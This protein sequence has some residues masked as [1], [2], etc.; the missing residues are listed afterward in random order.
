MNSPAPRHVIPLAPHEDLREAR[1]IIDQE[2][3]ALLDLSRRIDESFI[4]A[5]DRIVR[6][7][8]QIVVTGMGK[9][10]LIGQ[11]IA[12]TMSSTGTRA[13]FLHPS[14]ALHGDLG[15]LHCDDL[16]LALSNS[17]ETEEV[18]RLLPLVQRTG[19]PIIAITA[20]KTSTLGRNA[21][22]VI[23]LG[24]LR[25]AGPHGLAPTTSTTAMLALGDALALV[26]G[27]RRGL[28]PEKFALFHPGGRLGDQLRTVREVM[29]QGS[30][31]R[32]APSSATI[33]E[34]FVGLGKPGRRTGA[35][36]L[37]DSDQ[38]LVGLFTDSD[39][40]RLLEQ[41]RESQL[42]RPIS[43]VMTCNPL[44]IGPER[45]LRDA[46]ELLSQN[47]V[48]EL[49]VVDVFEQPI[50]LIDITDVLALVPSEAAA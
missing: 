4:A 35:V 50:G 11:K 15:K 48:S 34:A 6:T 7:N 45:M 19:A 9:A 24:R 17:G 2:A 21:E 38:R 3:R 16:L 18:C 26:A 47:K 28:T 33:R 44:T 30:D 40:A 14:E 42:D 29:R 12:A 31:L 5:L 1:S 10:G 37:V 22:I 39:L 20:T 27:Q 8:G 23:E 25:E 46:V 49:P 43:E 41:R 36:M 32:T 13:A